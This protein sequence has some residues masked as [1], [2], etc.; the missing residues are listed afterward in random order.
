MEGTRSVCRIAEEM[1]CPLINLWLGQDGYD[2]PLTTDYREQRAVLMEG[3]RTVAEEFPDQRNS[4]RGWYSTDQKPLSRR[5]AAAVRESV[6]FLRAVEELL[7]EERLGEIRALI[8]KGNATAS[9][10]WMR[11]V[12]LGTSHA[13]A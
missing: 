12:L 4:L 3:I 9:T 2:Y 1:T 8:A 6:A 7:T 5:W 10:R 13:A 11:Q